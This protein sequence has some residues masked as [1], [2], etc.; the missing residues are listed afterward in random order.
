MLASNAAGQVRHFFAFVKGLTRPVFR[1]LR[2]G[3]D[4]LLFTLGEFL[5]LGSA[6]IGFARIGLLWRREPFDGFVDRV[7][8]VVVHW[9][10]FPFLRIGIVKSRGAVL[11]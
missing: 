11:A 9:G 8:E 5:P 3:R 10:N 2:I 7:N 4:E 6:Q 1:T